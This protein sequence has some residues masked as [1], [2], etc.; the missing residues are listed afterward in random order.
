MSPE[1]AGALSFYQ[2]MFFAGE[3]SQSSRSVDPL[4]AKRSVDERYRTDPEFREWYDRRVAEIK[5]A[6]RNSTRIH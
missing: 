3:F 6:A 2:A 5:Q 4:A 1:S